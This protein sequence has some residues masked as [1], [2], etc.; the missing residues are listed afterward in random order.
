VRLPDGSLRFSPEFE[1][2][3]QASDRAR[4]ALRDVYEAASRAFDPSAATEP[5]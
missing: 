4:V 5:R 1:S 3:R 2:C